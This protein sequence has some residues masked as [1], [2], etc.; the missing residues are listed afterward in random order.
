MPSE[1]FRKHLR[2]SLRSLMLLVLILAVFL[3]WRANKARQQRRVVAAVEAYGGWVHY[4][5]ES[6][7]GKLTPG[8]RLGARLAQGRARG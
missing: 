5:Y 3:G 7:S 1:R 6:V 4:D 8:Q 2:F